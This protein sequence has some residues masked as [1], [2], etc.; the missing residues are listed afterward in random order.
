MGWGRALDAGQPAKRRG[1]AAGERGCLLF[2]EELDHHHVAAASWPERRPVPPAV[3]DLVGLRG[4]EEVARLSDDIP[5]LGVD[6]LSFEC[7][8]LSSVADDR[9]ARKD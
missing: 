3:R 9:D 1:L 6:E 8:L 7:E 5:R 4:H 2:V